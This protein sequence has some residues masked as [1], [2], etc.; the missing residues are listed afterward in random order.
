[1][2]KLNSPD[3]VQSDSSE[4]KPLNGELS[5]SENCSCNKIAALLDPVAHLQQED[6]SGAASKLAYIALDVREAAE[7]KRVQLIST[8]SRKEVTVYLRD[9]WYVAFAMSN[10]S[11]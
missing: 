6:P 1:M 11:F 5:I 4:H 3:Q 2:V 7:Q 9:G 8:A 10:F